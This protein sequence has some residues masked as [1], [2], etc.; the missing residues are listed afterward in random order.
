MHKPKTTNTIIILDFCCIT[1]RCCPN[2]SYA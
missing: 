2:D 1:L